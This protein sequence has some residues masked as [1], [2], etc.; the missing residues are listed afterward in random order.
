M[1][2]VTYFTAT[3]PMPHAYYVYRKRETRSSSPHMASY[4]DARYPSKL[5]L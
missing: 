5:V 3:S 4:G 1:F 2:R